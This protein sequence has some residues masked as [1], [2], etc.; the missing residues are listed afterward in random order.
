M[1][2]ITT[3]AAPSTAPAR[4]AAAAP[5][6]PEPAAAGAA[7]A[8]T[9]FDRSLRALASRASGGASTY[10]MAAA[11]LDWA[12]HMAI[13][14]GR[15][16]E[17]A[18][19]AAREVARLQQAVVAGGPTGE[20]P[21][22]HRFADPDWQK[23]PFRAWRDGF[24]A[25]ERIAAKATEPVPG[26]QPGNARRV[27]FMARQAMAF[28]SPAN[29]PASNPEILRTSHRELGANVVRGVKA[30]ADDAARGATGEPPPLAIRLGVDA[31]A[32]PGTV[33]YRNEIM[34]LIQYAPATSEVRREPV[35]V[36]PAW[37]MKYYILDLAPDRSLIR[38]LVQEGHTV[39][40]ISW[41]NPTTADR[42]NSFD[43][44][45]RRGLL[46]ALRAIDAIMP[47]TPVHACGYCLGGTM[48]AIGAAVA[49]REGRT[50]FAS[51]TLLAAQVDFSEAGELMMFIDE[52]QVTALEDLMWG[53]GVLETEQ[54]AS[55]FRF[56]RSDDLIW[57][58][59]MRSYWLG[60]KAP[61]SD[62]TAWNADQTRMPYRMHSEY[63]R[64]LFLENRLTAG[65]YAVD[66]ATVALKDIRCP[67]FVVGTETDHIAPWRSVYKIQ[68]FTDAETTFVL[69]NGGHNAGIV[70]QP[71]HPHRRHRIA[72]RLP[73]EPYV[74][75]DTWLSRHDP[76]PG[77]WWPAWFD[78][79]AR[80]GS[81]AM[82]APPGM[83]AP[84]RGYHALAPAPGTYVF[85]R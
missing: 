20:G 60:E 63:L 34:E 50:P 7:S 25:A 53:Q 3:A 6:P 12:W 54:M 77:S 70:S 4:P 66:G 76:L 52:S 31:A 22:D 21:A 30:M 29:W 8:L 58:Q 64:G 78:W 67:L 17:I 10:S 83:G 68:L 19:E 80:H 42:N 55:A 82:V 44:Y 41:K 38:H 65:R 23:E 43:S 14:P 47:D 75:P 28:A 45:R 48:L 5:S 62:L 81:P 51:L 33:V 39:F 1:Q 84:D 74:S 56:L 73:G 40:A 61:E 59:A 15:R 2:E 35:L 72:T 69:T 46:E 26:M 16:M 27:A 85:G 36:V 37:I 57:A 49:A 24:L 18:L 9:T 13:A 32:T 71:G 11:W 79:L